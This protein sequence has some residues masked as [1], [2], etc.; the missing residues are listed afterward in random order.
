MVGEAKPKRVIVYK[1][2]KDKEPYIDWLH[3]LQDQDGRRATLNRIGRLEYGNYGYCKSVGQ[4]VYELRN[5][6]GPGYRVYFGQR[7]DEVVLLL[8]GVKADRIMT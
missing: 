3:N 8:G 6:T 5:D 2:D 4:G 7:E 1:D